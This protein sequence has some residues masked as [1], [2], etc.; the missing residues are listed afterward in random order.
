ME[1]PNSK[2]L[3]AAKWILRFVKGTIGHGFI[4]KKG[5]KKVEIMGITIVTLQ[6]KIS[7]LNFQSKT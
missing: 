2:L 3:M 1:K 6:C 7:A 5:K 4:S